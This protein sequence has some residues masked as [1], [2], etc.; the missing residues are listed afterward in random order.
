[1]IRTLNQKICNRLVE[2]YSFLES[3]HVSCNDRNNNQI[4]VEPS[5]TLTTTPEP[6]RLLELKTEVYSLVQEQTKK[7]P[8]ARTGW[9]YKSKEE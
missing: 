6:D 3:I 1:M 2:K 5:L 8:V 9:H 7:T 4:Y